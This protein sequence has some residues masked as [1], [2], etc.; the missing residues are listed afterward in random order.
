MRRALTH[1]SRLITRLEEACLVYGILVLA[2]LSI[3]N[4]VGR[5]V[6]GQSLAFAEEVSAFLMIA[7]T[8]MGIGYATGQARHIRMTA[9]FDVLPVRWQKRLVL[10][11]S[12]LVAALLAIFTWLS[13]RYIFGTMQPLGSR[14]PVLGVPLYAVY[15][16][17]PV[18]LALGAVQNT[19]TFFRNLSDDEV[20]LSYTQRD[21][22]D[23]PVSGL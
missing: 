13:L 12:L 18:G 10:A 22:F 16:V 6:F 19:L 15:L 2:L 11:S 5:S 14:S 9:L 4:V 3:A 21:E 17:A 20:W 1:V 23:E 8:F 7:V